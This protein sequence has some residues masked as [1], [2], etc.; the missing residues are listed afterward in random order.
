MLTLLYAPLLAGAWWCMPA[1]TLAALVAGGLLAWVMRRWNDRHPASIMQPAPV[2]S[3]PTVVEINFS[4][5]RVPGDIGGLIFAAGAILIVVVGLP[6][7]WWFFVA[8]ALASG[9]VAWQRV[10]HLSR[11]A[12]HA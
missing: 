1:F 10:R 2:A 9:M 11:P 4:S 12:S 6:A 5:T 3:L 8:A 7:F